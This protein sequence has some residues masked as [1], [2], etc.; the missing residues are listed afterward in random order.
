[1]LPFRGECFGSVCPTDLLGEHF[2]LQ[3]LVGLFVCVC[4]WVF[5]SW[6]AYVFTHASFVNLEF[7]LV[8]RVCF[9]PLLISGAQRSST[10]LSLCPF[11][12][13]V[14][15]STKSLGHKIPPKSGNSEDSQLILCSSSSFWAVFGG[16]G[17]SKHAESL[18]TKTLWTSALF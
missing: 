3:C 14:Q 6:F 9:L 11:F 4:L 17:K 2:L 5:G 8:L 10:A 12:S 13:N 1:M 7:S 16:G 18:Q 15:M